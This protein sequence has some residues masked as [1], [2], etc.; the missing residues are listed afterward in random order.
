MMLGVGERYLAFWP[1]IM[2]RE[3]LEPI[4]SY[5]TGLLSMCPKGVFGK[6]EAGAVKG[7]SISEG[8]TKFFGEMRRSTVFRL[9]TSRGCGF[10]YYFCSR[11]TRSSAS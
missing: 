11:F 6:G 7:I 5:V 8:I 1:L 10:F 9:L 3:A 2:S 4:F